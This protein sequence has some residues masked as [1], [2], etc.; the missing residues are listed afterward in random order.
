MRTSTA[1]SEMGSD[2]R[3]SLTTREA[4]IM[5]IK[6]LLHKN[7]GRVT[8]VRSVGHRTWEKVQYWFYLCDVTWDDGSKS[9]GIEVMPDRLCADQ[10]NPEAMAEINKVSEKLNEHLHEHGTWLKKG[11]WVG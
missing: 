4:T 3:R 7:G 2:R 10:S 5:Q 6:H 9:S 11:K 8:T 1:E